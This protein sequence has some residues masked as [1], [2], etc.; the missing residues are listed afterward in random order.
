MAQPDGAMDAVELFDWL[1]NAQCVRGSRPKDGGLWVSGSAAPV[2]FD[3]GLRIVTL[4][5]GRRYRLRK[6][7]AAKVLG[8]NKAAEVFLASLPPPPSS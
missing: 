7:T 6:E 4:E 3:A 2:A 5:D 8:L 1:V